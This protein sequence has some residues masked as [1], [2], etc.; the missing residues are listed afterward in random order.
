MRVEDLR[1]QYPNEW[2]LL[3]VEEK[4]ALSVPVEGRLLA[5]GQDPEA[6]W[7]EVAARQGQFYI[8]YTGEVLK[9]MAVIF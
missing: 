1:H 9:D 4:D 8:F 2:I 3:A 7:D 6:L 5:H